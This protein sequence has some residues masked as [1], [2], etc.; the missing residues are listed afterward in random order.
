[1]KIIANKSG[2]NKRKVKTTRTPKIIAVII[3]LK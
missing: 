2:L 1:P 3:F